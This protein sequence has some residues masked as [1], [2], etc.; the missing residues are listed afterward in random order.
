MSLLKRLFVFSLMVATVLAY[1]PIRLEAA[2][3]YGAGSLL[4]LQGVKGAAV[5]YIGSDGKKYVYP[6]AKTYMTWY[7]NFDDVVRV[8]VTE[9]DLYPDGGAVT[10]RAGTKLVKH[11]N[12]AKTYALSSGGMLHWI[13]DE[14]TAKSLYGNDWAKRIQDVIPGY[15]SS[16]YTASTDLSNKYPDGT[17]VSMGSNRYYLEDGKKRPFASADAFEANNLMEANLIAVTDL[18]AYPDGSSITGEEIAISGFKPVAGG[19]GGGTGTLSVSLASDTPA[20]VIV[21]GG[22][23]RVPI[24]KVNFTNNGS[25]DVTVDQVIVER[26]GLAQDGAFSSLDLVD[27]ATM[28]PLNKS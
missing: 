14:A 4:A 20:S 7:T 28:L 17:L 11:E 1:T 15:F 12:T 21:V 19:G 2:G 13:P 3:N 24:T 26:Q 8:S 25:S 23:A 16:S 5:Y 10:Y 18:S 6:D 22:A 9:L 27:T